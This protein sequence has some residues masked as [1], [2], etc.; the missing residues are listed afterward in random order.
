M[1]NSLKF[2]VIDKNTDTEVVPFEVDENAISN[3]QEA[4]RDITTK[5]INN[6]EISKKDAILLTI[7]SLLYLIYCLL[8]SPFCQKKLSRFIYLLLKWH[9]KVK[10]FSRV[11]KF[12]SKNYH[13]RLSNYPHKSLKWGEQ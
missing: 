5:L 2:S 11:T 13:Q 9:T 6:D 10:L 8:N 12:Q 1:L 7:F 3:A 4:L